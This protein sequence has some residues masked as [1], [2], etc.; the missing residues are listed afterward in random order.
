MLRRAD[1]ESHRYIG[2]VS[3]PLLAQCKQAF[4]RYHIAF[5][6]DALANGVPSDDPFAPILEQ[7]CCSLDIFCSLYIVLFA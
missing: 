1:L 2:Y 7:N 6:F 4:I 5:Y 3:E